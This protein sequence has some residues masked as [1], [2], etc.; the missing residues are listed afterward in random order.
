MTYIDAHLTDYQDAIA[1]EAFIMNVAAL[2]SLIN[3]VDASLAAFASVQAAAT[4][5]D[6]SA[7]S[8]FTLLD[9]T[10]LVFNGENESDYQT[11][12]A[13]EASIADVAAL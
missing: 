13:A 6:A 2:Q 11:A 3:R 7:I 9:I 10:G 12:I 8:V 4:S 1:A 5:G